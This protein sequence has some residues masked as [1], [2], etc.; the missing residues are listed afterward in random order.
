[1]I[2]N[3]NSVNKIIDYL[4]HFQFYCG[5]GFV[6]I[7]QSEMELLQLN[8]RKAKEHRNSLKDCLFGMLL[9]PSN[10]ETVLCNPFYFCEK[11]VTNGVRLIL[12]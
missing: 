12:F 11:N 1:M 7:S 6:F 3:E 5:I 4:Q 8:N 2:K 9:V 10:D